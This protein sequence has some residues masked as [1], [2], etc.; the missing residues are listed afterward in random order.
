M[1]S[2][3]FD[4]EQ[5]QFRETLTEF[6][7]KRLMPDYH[8]RAALDDYPWA[9]HKALAEMGLLGI[10][11][12]EEFGG[13]G[14]DDF[15]ALG[16]ACE[17]IGYGDI[18]CAAVPVQTGLIGAQLAVGASRAL[19]EE[20]LPRLIAGDVLI[21]LALT[22]PESGS[23]AS[24]L[25]TVAVP[26]EDGYRL[27]GEKTS[28]S[29]IRFAE[30]AIVYARLP[31]TTGA[32]GVSAFLV[33]SDWPGVSVGRFNDMGTRPLGRGT[34]ALDDVFIP[35]DHLIGAEGQAFALVTGH[36][37][38]SRAGIALQ[39][40]GAARASLDEA[41]SY[42]KERHAFGRPIA[43]YQGVS[44]PL[45]EH[46]TYLEACRW[47]CY[48]TLWLR[49]Q[50]RDH[51]AQAAMCKWWGPRVSV[52]A[53]EAALLVHGHFGYSDELPLQQRLR[54]AFAYLMAD[55]TAEIQKLLIGRHYIGNEVLG[56]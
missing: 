19:Q 26:V 54:D 3:E 52:D 25:R 33:E 44:L 42:A 23:D 13:T 55:G 39:C 9:E 1:I 18:N 27:S 2:F 34:L 47:L 24:A 38:Y 53:M 41:A 46:Y 30:A 16:I 6:A 15:V 28:V 43:S 48:W 56:R 40:L 37:G 51:A 32:R 7:R 10:G 36:F 5:L 22:E 35:S 8:R 12:P 14:R 31:G 45:A 21:S 20:W 29:L 50:G 4:D 49:Q 11:L 17:E